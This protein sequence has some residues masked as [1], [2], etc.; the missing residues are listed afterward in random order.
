[1]AQTSSTRGFAGMAPEQRR[2]IASKG[3]RAAHQ[4]GHAHEWT[5]EEA[6]AAGH[7]G[8]LAAHQHQ[9]SGTQHTIAA[10]GTEKAPSKARRASGA[11]KRQT[12]KA[13]SE[14]AHSTTQQVEAKDPDQQEPETT[15]GSDLHPGSDNESI[16]RATVEARGE[17]QTRGEFDSRTE[18]PGRSALDE[19]EERPD[20]HWA[21]SD[22][23]EVDVRSTRRRETELRPPPGD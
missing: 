15:T 6:A 11:K 5:S 17:P 16:T 9:R 7:L 8:G 20:E 1:M 18:Y 14:T 10:E 4:S 21:G 23:E 19:S 22:P 13:P 2:K 3:G 12:G